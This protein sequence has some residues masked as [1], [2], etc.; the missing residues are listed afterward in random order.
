[1]FSVLMD[2]FLISFSGTIQL[3]SDQ[4]RESIIKEHIK[5]KNYKLMK[6]FSQKYI[7]NQ[8]VTH[9]LF[10]KACDLIGPKL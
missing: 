6:R 9:K 3:Y 10:T 4:L 7:Q 2:W 1:M 5:Y 8:K